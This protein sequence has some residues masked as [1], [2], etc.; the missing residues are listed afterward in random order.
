M[1][2]SIDSMFINLPN[3]QHNLHPSFKQTRAVMMSLCATS[4]AALLNTP[5]V[6]LITKPNEKSAQAVMNQMSLML[7]M[8]SQHQDTCIL[9]KLRRHPYYV[10]TCAHH[11]E[12]VTTKTLWNRLLTTT[13]PYPK[14][15]S[16][17]FLRSVI[18]NSYIMLPN[19]YIIL[20]NSYIM[21]HA[22]YPNG[23]NDPPSCHHRSW[24]KSF[25][26]SSFRDSSTCVFRSW[27]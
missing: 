25:A 4:R 6:V 26:G 7:A 1:L 23:V 10:R 22:S 5:I 19:S 18:P 8:S 15:P 3:Q 27:E 2:S 11:F 14:A 9:T 17:L 12:N 21:R 20:P 24:N 13:T 16:G